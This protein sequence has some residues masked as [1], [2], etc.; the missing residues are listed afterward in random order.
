MDPEFETSP[1]PIVAVGLIGGCGALA[2]FM[3]GRPALAAAVCGVTLVVMALV[4]IL[5][6]NGD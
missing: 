4:R 2:A 6:R 5:T 3:D 1:W